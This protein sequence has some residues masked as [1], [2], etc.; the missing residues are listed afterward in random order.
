MKHAGVEIVS[1]VIA[2]STEAYNYHF[3]LMEPSLQDKGNLPVSVAFKI[4]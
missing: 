3:G 1:D 4:K 2:K